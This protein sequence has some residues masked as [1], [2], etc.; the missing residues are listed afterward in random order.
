[1]L[2]SLLKRERYI[3]MRKVFSLIT[4]AIVM[5]SWIPSQA[6]FQNPS[7]NF[8]YSPASVTITATCTTTACPT[9]IL[10]AL[11]TMTVRITGTNSALAVL[12]RVSNDAGANYSTVTPLIVGIA[13]NGTITTPP[14]IAANGIYSFTAL[15]M[16]RVR[17][18]V[19]TLTGTNATFK[20]VGTNACTSQAL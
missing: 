18:E 12:V 13:G 1:V 20:V 15:T 3:T 9:F 2:Y 8:V 5:F 7:P 14:T 16:N 19:S 10:P 17:F 6:Q 4:L 11:C